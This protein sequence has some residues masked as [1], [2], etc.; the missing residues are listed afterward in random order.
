MSC[1]L[2]SSSLV[3]LL[4]VVV[5]V[6]VVV[7]VVVDVVVVVVVVFILSFAFFVD[8]GKTPVEKYSTFSTQSRNHLTK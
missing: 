5:G 6:V 8:F 4:L 3:L 7:V 2:L 1:E